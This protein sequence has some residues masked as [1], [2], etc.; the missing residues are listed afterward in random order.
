MPPP[1]PPT[2]F[3]SSPGSGVKA[4]ILAFKSMSSFSRAGTR[5]RFGAQPGDRNA[6][7]M[8]LPFRTRRAAAAV[9]GFG[10]VRKVA[11]IR[12]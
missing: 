1:T 7:V 8:S 3:S 10:V 9:T 6:R 4:S 11:T 12:T 5:S 2:S